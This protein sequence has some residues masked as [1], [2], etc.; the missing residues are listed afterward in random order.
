MLSEIKRLTL[1]NDI[2]SIKNLIKE[3]NLS[4]IIFL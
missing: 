3:K 4:D 2:E 1:L